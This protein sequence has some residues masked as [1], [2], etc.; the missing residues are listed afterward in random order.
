MKTYPRIGADYY[1]PALDRP[2]IRSL[3][4]HWSLETA[5]D[6]WFRVACRWIANVLSDLINWSKP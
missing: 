1:G 4:Q 6:P 5:D 3:P 2:A